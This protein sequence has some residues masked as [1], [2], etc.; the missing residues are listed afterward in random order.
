MDQPRGAVDGERRFG[1]AAAHV[2]HASG[3]LNRRLAE[4]TRAT[5][6][7]PEEANGAWADGQVGALSE[8]FATRHRDLLNRLAE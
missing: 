6:P 4:G 7:E 2:L 3:E 5:E 1:E 8:D